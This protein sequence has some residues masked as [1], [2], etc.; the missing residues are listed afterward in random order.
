MTASP[1]RSAR[2]G[3]TV[4]GILDELDVALGPNDT[5]TPPADTPTQNGMLIV[6]DRVT[7]ALVTRSEPIPF[8]TQQQPDATLAKGST[9][10]VTPG[11]NGVESVTYTD[12]YL[13]GMQTSEVAG[14]ATVI[15]PAVAQVVLVGTKASTAIGGTPNKAGT[16]FKPTA[17]AAPKTTAPAP[18]KTTPPPAP[19]TTAP[20]PAP[21]SSAPPSTGPSVPPD[22]SGLNW[23]AVA[24]CESGGNWSINTGNG[25]YGGLQFSASTWISNGGGV[26]APTANLATKAQQIA[27]AN[28][29]YA[30]RGAAP[31]PTCGKYL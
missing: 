16:P 2:L 12:T 31:W 29:L 19:P 11:V 14:A 3:G 7:Y 24:Q 23:D 5:V 4:G 30:A 18:P 21:T 20:A 8:T 15:T 13:D 6:V 9:V 1:E 26:Y 27:I 17:P 28:K 22:T 10:V 25:Y